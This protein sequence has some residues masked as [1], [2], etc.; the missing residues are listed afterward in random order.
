[1]LIDAQPSLSVEYVA[2]SLSLKKRLWWSI[3][4]RDRSLCIGLRRRPQVTSVRLHGWSDWLSIDDFSEELY[5]SQVYDYNTKKCLLDA[6]LKQC[7][8][9]VLLT[10]MVSLAF[11]HPKTPR[12]LLSMIE[13][14]GLLST[15]KGIKRSLDGWKLPVPLNPPSKASMSDS[16]D[17]VTRLTYITY[18][19]YQFVNPLPLTIVK[20]NQVS[21]I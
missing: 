21:V 6:L 16:H 14:Q 8:L 11:A 12:R 4:L 18:M 2:I 7:E 13:F 1:M 17:P 10:D 5:H 19:Y 3:L 9:A 20:A 15:I